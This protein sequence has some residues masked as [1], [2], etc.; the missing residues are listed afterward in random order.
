MCVPSWDL[1]VPRSEINNAYVIGV[2][3]GWTGGCARPAPGWA[4]RAGGGGTMS[5][6]VT[7]ERL[8]GPA[9]EHPWTPA[10]DAGA[11]VSDEPPPGW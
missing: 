9:P 4:F 5:H 6:T 7:R 2:A 8:A 10:A 1:A 3:A 11:A